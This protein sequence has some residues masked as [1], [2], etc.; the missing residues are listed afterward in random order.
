MILLLVACFSYIINSFV[1]LACRLHIF[2]LFF[3]AFS[4]SYCLMILRS[5]MFV[6]LVSQFSLL[7][8]LTSVLLLCYVQLHFALYHSYLCSI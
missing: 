8:G 1:I 5:I 3:L 4:V 7:L 2:T 6:I